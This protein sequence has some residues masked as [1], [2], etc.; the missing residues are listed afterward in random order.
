MNAP[1]DNPA[2]DWFNQNA[3]P[4][5]VAGRFVELHTWPDFS[6]PDVA[7]GNRPG[8]GAPLQ[9]TRRGFM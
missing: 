6:S 1:F 4:L 8:L 9:R 7:I 2:I 3:R 5:K